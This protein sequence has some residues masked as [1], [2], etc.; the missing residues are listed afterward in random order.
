MPAVRGGG[1]G[2]HATLWAMPPRWPAQD[3]PTPR[4]AMALQDALRGRVVRRWSGRAPR[5]VAGADVSVR[6]ERARAAVC[7]LAWPGL[8]V[9]ERAL[10]QERVRFPYVPGL[11]GFREVPCLLRAFARLARRPDVVLVDGQG[12][13]H[14][15]RFGVACHL[16]VELDLPTVSTASPGRGAGRARA[17]CTRAS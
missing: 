13:A 15:R 9:L 11:L 10:A 8:E 1:Q 17:W 12:L 7:V 6:G 16:G 4:E 2:L 5:T 3:A 14:P